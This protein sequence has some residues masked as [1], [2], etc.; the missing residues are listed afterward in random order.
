MKQ[1]IFRVT[2]WESLITILTLFPYKFCPDFS[3]NKRTRSMYLTWR[4][5]FLF[6]DGV[7][8]VYEFQNATV[9]LLLVVPPPHTA[10]PHTAVPRTSC[11]SA[12]ER[13]SFRAVYVFN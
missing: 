10:S 6:D 5:R 12:G 13:C 3:G 1:T 9:Y 8:N 7:I 2:V 4:H 11:R